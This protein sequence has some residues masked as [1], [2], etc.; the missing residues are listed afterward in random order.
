MFPADKKSNY[1]ILIFLIYSFISF[2][3]L[4]LIQLKMIIIFKTLSFIRMNILII[5]KRSIKLEITYISH[6]RACL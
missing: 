5:T 2:F 3:Y 4:L 6:I 1:F